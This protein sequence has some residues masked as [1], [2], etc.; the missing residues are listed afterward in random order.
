MDTNQ[1]Q[2]YSIFINPQHLNKLRENIWNDEPLPATLE[3]SKERYK[4][5]L[6]Y[7]GSHIREF[8][9]KSYEISFIKP[10]FFFSQ[11]TIHLNAEYIDPSFMRNKLSFDF[12]HELG[13]LSPKTRF[14][15]LYIN[16]KFEGL[17]L[18]IEAVDKHFFRNRGLP[19]GAIFYAVDD[20]ANFSLYSSL[21]KDY[22]HSLD[23]GYERKYGTKRDS[24]YLCQIIYKIN[25]LKQHEFEREITN[26]IDVEKYLRWLIGVICT[27][28]FDGFTHNYA[29]YI[30]GKTKKAEII[31]WDYDAT[32][33]R[34]IH[35][36]KMAYDFIPITGYNTLTARVLNV[37]DFRNLYRHILEKVLEEQFCVAHLQ[38]KIEKLYKSI[39]PFAIR[40]PYK[41][42]EIDRFLKEPQFILNYI[43]QR[44]TYLK[45]KLSELK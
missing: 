3:F 7:R 35:G 42:K 29:L 25:T 34:D 11:T 36:N 32:W 27:Q 44:Q 20:D 45:E 13:V 10:G 5:A 41:K 8:P 23:L 33:G 6:M 17:Y 24:E 18:Q 38:P 43:Q 12:F 28:N 21:D 40:D 19:E 31:P 9:K 4:I 2:T 16:G 30:N 37:P 15:S 22:K 14:I 39:H 26:Y 1:V